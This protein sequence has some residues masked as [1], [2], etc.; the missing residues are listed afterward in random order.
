[1]VEPVLA[2]DKPSLAGDDSQ[3]K[4]DVGQSVAD[5]RLSNSVGERRLEQESCLVEKVSAVYRVD[6]ELTGSADCKCNVRQSDDW[7]MGL[8]ECASQ[9]VPQL[10]FLLRQEDEIRHSTHAEVDDLNF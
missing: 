9:S 6:F 8:V 2:S 7:P 3:A 5:D 4:G 1:M 10:N